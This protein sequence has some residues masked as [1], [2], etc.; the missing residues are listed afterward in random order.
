MTRNSRCFS[1]LSLYCKLFSQN[2]TFW[3]NSNM[4]VGGI[5]KK[6]EM[7]YKK[8]CIYSYRFKL[9]SPSK[10]SLFDDI[11]LLRCSSRCSKQFLNSSILVPYLVLLPFFVWPLLPHQQ[12]VS[13]WWLL[14]SGEIKKIVARGKT[15]WIRRVRLRGHAVCG[16]KLLNIQRCGGRCACKSAVMKW[17]NELKESSKKFTESES[18][19]SHHQL[20]HWFR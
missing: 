1:C 4:Y 17:A 2:D 20:I 16:Q 12:N 11:Q 15:E 3:L 9:Q 19:L 5:P 18:S 8:L 14:S 13:F 7:I 10:Y 6:P